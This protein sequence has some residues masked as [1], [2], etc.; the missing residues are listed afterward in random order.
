M[1]TFGKIFQ[2]T[3]YG[4]SHQDAIGVVIDGRDYVKKINTSYH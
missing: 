1:N 2:V 3:L 4:E